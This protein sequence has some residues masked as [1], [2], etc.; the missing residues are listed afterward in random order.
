MINLKKMLV[1]NSYMDLSRA[2]T[3]PTV[4]IVTVQKQ[5]LWRIIQ[6]HAETAVK[7]IKVFHG[8]LA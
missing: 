8:I 5:K 3:H 6:K 1:A 2:T 7:T 4:L